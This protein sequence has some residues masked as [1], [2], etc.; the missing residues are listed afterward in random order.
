[1]S[2]TCFEIVVLG[3]NSA[4]AITRTVLS[5]IAQV[6]ASAIRIH[7]VAPSFENM[8][9]R[10]QECANALSTAGMTGAN[11]ISMVHAQAPLRPDALRN[12]LQSIDASHSAEFTVL[13]EGAVLYPGALALVSAC[14]AQNIRAPIVGGEPIAASAFTTNPVTGA[15]A[16]GLADGVFFATRPLAGVFAP[17][18]IW[19]AALDKCSRFQLDSAWQWEIQMCISE[20]SEPVFCTASLAADHGFELADAIEDRDSIVSLERRCQNFIELLQSEQAPLSISRLDKHGTKT[21]T[22][23]VGQARLLSGADEGLSTVYQ[24]SSAAR[25]LRDRL[26][27]VRDEIEGTVTRFD[28]DSF[29]AQEAGQRVREL[30]NAVQKLEHIRPLLAAFDQEAA[31]LIA[32]KPLDSE[33][34][35]QTT[36]EMAEKL[37]RYEMATSSQLR[38]EIESGKIEDVNWKKALLRSP[39]KISYWNAARRFARNSGKRI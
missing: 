3:E 9:T 10:W 23:C 37:R 12:V 22:D 5:A 19:T 30:R 27:G 4:E 35:G 34:S 28:A 24:A 29:A 11:E 13:P 32:D 26:R 36:S 38:A 39:G 7:V 21:L 1:M 2:K 25:N 17:T 33:F 14:R 18:D 15:M 16:R 6:G 20:V 8:G 31:R